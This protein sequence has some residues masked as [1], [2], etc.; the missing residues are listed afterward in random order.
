V[1]LRRKVGAGDREKGF[2]RISCGRWY[3]VFYGLKESSV[4]IP[5]SKLHYVAFGKGCKNLII[6]QG[7]NVRDLQGAGASLALMYRLFAKDYRVYFFDRRANVREGLTNWDLAEDIYCAMEALHIKSADVL[8]VSQG[9]MI[10][11]ALALEHPKCIHKLV[12]GVTA[13]RVNENIKSVVSKWIHCAL[14]QDYVTINQDTFSLMYTETYLRKYRLWMPLMI[15]MIKPRDFHRFAILASAILDF[16]CYDR[17]QEI[18]C[19]VLV[20]GGEKDM[21]TTGKASVEIA[22]KLDCRI[23]MY[24]EYG[25]AAYDEAKDFNRI[26]YEFF[27]E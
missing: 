1:P 21:I 8:G 22:D 12:L 20:I 16:D 14:H 27:S 25:H 19:P 23:H 13:A 3:S 7:L 2:I 17:L 5:S 18:Q 26:I 6:I 10:A 4:D 9:G 11:M 24:P 15:R